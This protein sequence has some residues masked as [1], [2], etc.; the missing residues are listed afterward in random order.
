MRSRRV[1][2]DQAPA[3]RCDIDRAAADR[4]GRAVIGDRLE[5]EFALE[6]EDVADLV[7]DPGEVA[8]GQ[9]GRLI[10][11]ALDHGRMVARQA[12]MTRFKRR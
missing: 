8:V 7:E 6:F 11:R 1:V 2:A 3:V 4:I 10:R 12:A 5:D 9:L